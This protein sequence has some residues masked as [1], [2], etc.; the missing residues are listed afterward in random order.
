MNGRWLRS[1]ILLVVVHINYCQAVNRTKYDVASVPFLTSHMSNF[2]SRLNASHR[3][4]GSTRYV[5]TEPLVVLSPCRMS[6]NLGPSKKPNGEE[7]RLMRL[8]S[9]GVLEPGDS[10]YAS[11]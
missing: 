1:S 4:D 11:E 8:T 7:K 10:Y 3:E 9:A 2:L 5:H 6:K